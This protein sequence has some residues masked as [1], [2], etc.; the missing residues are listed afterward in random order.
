MMNLL[1]ALLLAPV[2]GGSI[3]DNSL[4]LRDRLEGPTPVTDKDLRPVKLPDCRTDTE[5]QVALEQIRK[6][7]PEACFIRD[8]TAFRDR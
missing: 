2:P 4:I 5:V 3:S 6:G 7:E 1:I 8:R